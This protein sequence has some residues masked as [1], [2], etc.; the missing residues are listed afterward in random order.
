MVASQPLSDDDDDDER[1][2]VP[3]LFFAEA[4]ECFKT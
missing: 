2:L 1:F 3:L 4:K